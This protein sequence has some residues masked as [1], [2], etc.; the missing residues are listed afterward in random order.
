MKIQ[1]DQVQPKEIEERSFQIIT[2]ELEKM[3]IELK[4]PYAPIVKRVIHTTADFDYAKNL[5]FSPDVLQLALELL[6][7][8]AC[9]VTDTQIDRKSVV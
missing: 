2:E 1:L 9:I 8:K 3:Q 5:V 7:R 4:E 6:K